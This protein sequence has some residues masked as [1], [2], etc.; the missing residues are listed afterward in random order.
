MEHQGGRLKPRSNIFFQSGPLRR[1]KRRK[2]W[3]RDGGNERKNR[4][5]AALSGREYEGQQNSNFYYSM[6]TPK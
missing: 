5:I 1:G 2:D 6:G 4:N 3:R